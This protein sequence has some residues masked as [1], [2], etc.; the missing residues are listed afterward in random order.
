MSESPSPKARPF[1][2]DR[3]FDGDRVVEPVRP[4]RLFTPEELETA[5]AA[6]FAEG[7]RSAT[8]R[9]EAEMASALAAL[10]AAAQRGLGALTGLAHGHKGAASELALAAGKTIAGAALARFPEAPAA[11]ALEALARELS[12]VP[13]LIVRSGAGDR[14][15][16]EAAL[17]EAAERAGYSGQILLRPEPGAAEAAFEFDWGEGSARFDPARAARA[18]EAALT[19]AL[20]AEAAGAAE[21]P[22]G[23]V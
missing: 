1:T 11:E 14:A 7:E 17:A 16:L 23:E 8:A 21:V 9:A 22:R 20:E 5:R 12:A 2:F 6:A 10:A 19:R 3:V 18:V 15:R 4:K 13:K